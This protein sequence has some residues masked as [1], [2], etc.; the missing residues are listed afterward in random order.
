MQCIN[1][2]I[3]TSITNSRNLHDNFNPS[4]WQSVHDYG[5]LS[6]YNAQ[7]VHLIDYLP[8]IDPLSELVSLNNDEKKNKKRENDEN[9]HDKKSN[10]KIDYLRD[11]NNDLDG[12]DRNQDRLEYLRKSWTWLL[13]EQKEGKFI[14]DEMISLDGYIKTIAK[15]EKWLK[16]IHG[17]NEMIKGL[18]EKSSAA[19]ALIG[20]FGWKAPYYNVKEVSTSIWC[21]V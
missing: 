6:A 5:T 13:H 16:R 18:A 11:H 19:N 14:A 15:K 4:V 17:W 12:T 1:N 2:T 21:G 9:G 3:H 20:S 8:R 10:N 7:E